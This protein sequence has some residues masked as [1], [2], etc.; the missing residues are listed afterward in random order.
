MAVADH[1]PALLDDLAD[2]LEM[3]TAPWRWNRVYAAA[4]L[5][6]LIA[7][8]WRAGDP[9]PVDSPVGGR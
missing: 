4:V 7:L 8:G 3:T 5:D 1:D 6:R 9:H 2:Q